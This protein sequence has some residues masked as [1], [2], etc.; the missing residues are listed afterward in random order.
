MAQKNLYLSV[1]LDLGGS[2]V[3][4]MREENKV[5]TFSSTTRLVPSTE[6]RDFSA[7][8]LGEFRIL[9][10]PNGKVVNDPSINFYV[11]EDSLMNYSGIDILPNNQTH[12]VSQQSTY[13]NLIYAI[14]ISL[15]KLGYDVLN[16]VACGVCVPAAEIYLSRVGETFMRDIVGEHVIEFPRKNKTYTFNLDLNTMTLQGEGIVA[17]A[18]YLKTDSSLGKGTVLIL[19]A[20][21]RSTEILLV[22][23]MKPYTNTASSPEL[24]GINIE[25]SIL[26]TLHGQNVLGIDPR[27]VVITGT[28]PNYG[29]VIEAGSAV[30]VAKQQ[31]ANKLAPHISTVVSNTRD[32][33]NLRNIDKMFVTGRCFEMHGKDNTFTGDLANYILQSLGIEVPIFRAPNLGNANVIGT[34]N[35]LLRK[36]LK[37]NE[38]SV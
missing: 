27:K 6:I 5:N 10:T 25:T 19:D 30:R 14:G 3:R 17:Y 28:F 20:G 24:G 22:Q 2:E 33:L 8:L 32:V 7:N 21:Y 4:Y 18:D 35:Q 37:N 1:A 13:I 11:K 38:N 23:N 9:K 12:K 15:D 16:T 26:S 34:Y 31:L 29:E 36:L